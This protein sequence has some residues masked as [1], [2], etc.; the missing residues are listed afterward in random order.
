LN[1]LR[2]TVVQVHDQYFD[3]TRIDPTRM[4]ATMLRAIVERSDGLLRAESDALSTPAG[5]RW[6]IPSPRTIWNIPIAVRDLG[7]FLLKHLPDQHRLVKG[8]FSEVVMTN[9]MLSTLDGHSVLIA[10]GVW[11]ALRKIWSV[12][13]IA[14]T[15][16]GALEARQSSPG[17]DAFTRL[18]ADGILY[19]RPSWFGADTAA[20]IRSEVEKA[21][22]HDLLGV[23]LDLR[24]NPGGSLEATLR[25]ADL[26]L[27][28]G[29]MLILN[30]RASAEVKTASADGL[31]TERLKLI[32]LVDSATGGGAEMV[33]GALRFGDRALLLG[34]TTAGSGLIQVVFDFKDR[35]SGDVSGLELTIAEALLPGDRAFAGRGIAPD[36]EMASNGPYDRRVAQ[37]CAPIGEMLATVRSQPGQPDP[38][39]AFAAR[40][41]KM[42]PTALRADLLIA[43]KAAAASVG[44]SA[45]THPRAP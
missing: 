4:L 19:L 15:Q 22:T 27:A 35:D 30:G 16:P 33:A 42:A 21:S 32:V 7:D 18:D 12:A 45:E 24:A 2:K 14:V 36:L 10:P 26:F 38:S 20:R 34:E 9:A 40:I 11:A 29:A 1:L 8:A 13:G 17:S 31:A 37:A 23:V 5:E 25:I 44:T 3:S 39:L 28:T 41:L 6:K 43:A